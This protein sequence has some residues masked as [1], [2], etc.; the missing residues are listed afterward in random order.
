MYRVAQGKNP[1][2]DPWA[3]R[4]ALFGG[5]VSHEAEGGFSVAHLVQRGVN[6]H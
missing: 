3:E 5:E 4:G 1:V 2:D 6:R